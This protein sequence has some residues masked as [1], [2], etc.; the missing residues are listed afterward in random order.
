MLE[1][2]ISSV[3]VGLSDTGNAYA[4]VN[5]VAQVRS[6]DTGVWQPI[7]PSGQVEQIS[8]AIPGED[9]VG[10]EVVIWSGSG[11]VH[12]VH[13]SGYGTFPLVVTSGLNGGQDVTAWNEQLETT[14]GYPH[15]VGI[16]RSNY[17]GSGYLSGTAWI[18]QPD[19]STTYSEFI[20]TPATP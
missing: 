6:P 15:F 11:T 2:G 18:Q 13:Q 10:E 8:K 16:S 4:T 17:S 5:G 3:T 12:F 7:A 9:L 1:E 19:G 20:L 14:Y